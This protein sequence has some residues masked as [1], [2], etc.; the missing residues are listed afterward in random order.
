MRLLNGQELA[1]YIKQQQLRQFRSL[2]SQYHIKAKLAVIVTINDPV[3]ELYI[4]LK[5]HY[6]QDIGVNVEIFRVNMTD[7]EKTVKQLNVDPTFQGV[8]IQ[9]PLDDM[10]R[11]DY[12][13]NLLDDQKD[14][15]GLSLHH[16]L[17][18]A[19][20]KAILWLLAGFNID[21]NGQKILIV[22]Q[23]R[24]V[25]KPLTEIL[26]KSDLNINITTA[27]EK[28]KDLKSL[29]LQSNIIVTATGQSGLITNDMINP[30][31]IIVDAGTTSENGQIVGDVDSNLYERDDLTITPPKGGVG[32]LTICALF[33]N[34]YQT[35]NNNFNK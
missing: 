11:V 25:G 31:T 12:Y 8:I 6:G 35:I 19:T 18:P 27:D 9:L 26:Q 13:L 29:C 32:P 28:T 22:G 3:I 1:G 10:S 15:D 14:V 23:G 7:L 16:S 34:L 30:K 33:D 5:S 24:L 2:W 21:L 20:P 4:K 17:D